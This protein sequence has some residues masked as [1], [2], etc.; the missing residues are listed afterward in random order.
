MG[1][2]LQDSV[3]M[4]EILKPTGFDIPASVANKT[5]GEATS[6]S[7]V[8]VETNKT[9]TISTLGE[10]VITPTSGKDAMAKV[11]ATVSPV[12]Y[13]FKSEADA[14]VY[15]KV[16]TPTTSDKALVPASTGI[17]EGVIASVGEGSITIGE[18]AYSAYATGNITL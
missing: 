10:N 8:K 13:A 17:T 7:D 9:V 12:L 15:T 14:I 3:P 18:T 16:A 4:K 5:W 6:G 1:A 2:Q 11:T